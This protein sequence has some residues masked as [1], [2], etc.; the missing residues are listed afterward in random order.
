MKEEIKN[1]WV[2]ALRSNKYKQGKGNLR[3][4]NDEFCC[5]GV[6]CDISLQY[7][8]LEWELK[9]LNYSILN[10]STVLPIEVM[11]WADIKM[12]LGEYEK[13]CLSTQNDIGKSFEE[14]ADIIEKYWE[15]L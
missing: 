14:I 15:T 13:S 7:S 8:L 3:N 10:H 6:L 12:E 11:N 1:L 5:L 4:I 9:S 2:E